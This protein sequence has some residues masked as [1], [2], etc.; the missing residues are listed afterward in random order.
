MAE[1]VPGSHWSQVHVGRRRERIARAEERFVVR[2]V[3]VGTLHSPSPSVIAV[4]EHIFVLRIK[5][6]EIALPLAAT[7]SRDLDEAFVQRQVVPDRILPSLLILLE[8]RELGGDVGV[9][10]A[11]GRPLLRALLYRHGDQG[12][13]AEGRLAVRG[14]GAAVVG[15]VIRAGRDGGHGTVGGGR[16]RGGRGGRGRRGGI[17]IGRA[18][19]GAHRRRA[20]VVQVMVRR[21]G[22]GGGVGVH[23]DHGAGAV[24][25]VMGMMVVVV[26]VVVVAEGDVVRRQIPAAQAAGDRRGVEVLRVAADAAARQLGHETAHLMKRRQ[27]RRRRRRQLKRL[28]FDLQKRRG[29]KG[30]LHTESC[31]AM[32]VAIPL[33]QLPRNRDVRDHPGSV[34]VIHKG[35]GRR[36]CIYPMLLQLHPI[37]G[38]ALH[39]C[40]ADGFDR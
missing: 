3:S 10:L 39:N 20:L 5:R 31:G 19:K 37:T 21:A 23:R 17:A 40:T 28:L 11:E 27:G 32:A 16:D 38:V 26:M 24:Q 34:H 12:D 33:L 25:T 35:V 6:P 9:D 18:V 36:R 29:M 15:A 14:G 13:V 30:L 2:S 22:G 8:V 7:L 1:N 4:L